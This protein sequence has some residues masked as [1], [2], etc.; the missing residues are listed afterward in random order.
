MAVPIHRGFIPC[1]WFNDENENAF[2]YREEETLALFALK[3]QIHY[4]K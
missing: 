3:I 1:T 2:Q 4:L